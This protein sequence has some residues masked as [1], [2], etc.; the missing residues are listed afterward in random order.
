M[1]GLF[2]RAIQ[3]LCLFLVNCMTFFFFSTILCK[4][5]DRGWGVGRG[6]EGDLPTPGGSLFRSPCLQSEERSGKKN[7][8]VTFELW[9]DVRRFTSTGAKPVSK[10]CHCQGGDV[11]VE[12]LTLP[13]ASGCSFGLLGTM[14]LAATVPR[15]AVFALRCLLTVTI[16]LAMSYCQFTFYVAAVF[17][18]DVFWTC[19]FFVFFKKTFGGVAGGG[20]DICWLALF[21]DTFGEGAEILN[22]KEATM[23][24]HVGANLS[25]ALDN[26][27]RRRDNRKVN[28]LRRRSV[29]HVLYHG[30]EYVWVREK[31]HSPLSRRDLLHILDASFR[32]DFLNV[33]NVLV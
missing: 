11:Y 3:R 16:E 4:G 22:K 17:A 26:T 29:H 14:S 8:R 2:F 25:L 24:N 32:E 21:Q 27:E 6:G 10:H 20:G 28:G 31:P 1:R 30:S 9:R 18:L 15:I 33:F 12:T 13:L 23:T 19:L 5:W 7:Q